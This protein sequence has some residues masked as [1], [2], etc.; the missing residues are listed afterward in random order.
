MNLKYNLEERLERAAQLR[1]DGF[2]C[3]QALVLS[4]PDVTLLDDSNG[5]RMTAALGTGC[6]AMGEICGVAN[7]IAIV[8]GSLHGADAAAKVP[9]A[10]EANA[11]LKAF[12]EGNDGRIICRELKA[13]GARRACNDLVFQGVELLHNHLAA[14]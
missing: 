10:R 11:L 6:A 13:P 4:F 14:R 1:R 12:K 9:A 8:I 2:N 5:A 7:G 3:A